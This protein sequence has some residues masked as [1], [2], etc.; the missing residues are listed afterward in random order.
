MNSNR[1]LI[2]FLAAIFML[3]LASCGGQQQTDLGQAPDFERLAVDGA[4][5]SLDDYVGK[6]PVLLYFHMA[7]G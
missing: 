4:Q 6:Q 3:L 1:I 5:V 7:V 2:R